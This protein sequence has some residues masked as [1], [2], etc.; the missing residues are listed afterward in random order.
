M[1]ASYPRPK[2]GNVNLKRN[3]DLVEN[4]LPNGRRA[5]S[6]SKGQWMHGARRMARVTL[7]RSLVHERSYIQSCDLHPTTDHAI[8]DIHVIM[9]YT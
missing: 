9:V 2:G 5:S 6:A 8:H 1:E 4:A 3:T 7:N